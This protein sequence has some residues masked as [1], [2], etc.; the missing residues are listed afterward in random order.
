ML[1]LRHTPIQITVPFCNINKRFQTKLS[2]K[3]VKN[4][5]TKENNKTRI[6]PVNAKSDHSKYKH[7]IIVKVIK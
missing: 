5:L 3:S 4:L 1:L 2:G 6:S 7:H